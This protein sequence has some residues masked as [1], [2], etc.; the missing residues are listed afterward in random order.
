MRIS[1]FLVAVSL[2]GVLL[3][4][5]PST[6]NP[7]GTNATRG[8]SKAGV[9]QLYLQ[10]LRD[11]IATCMSSPLLS[12]TEK[13][14]TET[15]T[16]DFPSWESIDIQMLY[17]HV[18]KLRYCPDIYATCPVRLLTTEEYVQGINPWGAA[19]ITH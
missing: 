4:S 15:E 8:P 12:N 14:C 9:K 18:W 17:I 5:V 7:V 11:K 6:G 19:F 16:A 10:D 13:Y 2:L 3:F 1:K